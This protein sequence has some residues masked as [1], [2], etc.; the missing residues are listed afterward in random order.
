VSILENLLHRLFALGLGT[1]AETLIARAISRRCGPMVRALLNL[2]SRYPSLILVDSADD[3]DPQVSPLHLALAW[4]A[5]PFVTDLAPRV[6]ATTLNGSPD[7]PGPLF[8]ILDV[9]PMWSH[10]NRYDPCE[11]ASVIVHMF[12]AILQEA[13]DD[14]SRLLLSACRNLIGETL[15]EAI[16][17]EMEYCREVGVAGNNK[18]GVTRIV[19]LT[20]MRDELQ[21]ALVRQQRYRD[22][23]GN[24]IADVL[25]STSLSSS[26]YALAPLFREYL[27]HGLSSPSTIAA[28]PAQS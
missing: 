8:R 19:H 14:G 3:R 1:S 15:L 27:V 26:A 17:R 5:M 25:Y 22:S 12:H 21:A 28:A 13:H 16:A 23:V 7:A 24:V 4:A 18:L 11:S 9:T 6:S 20:T 10:A 2:Q